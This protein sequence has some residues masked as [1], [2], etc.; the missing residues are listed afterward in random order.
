MKIGE[1]ANVTGASVRSI[2]YY[3][4]LGLVSALRTSGGQRAF[5]ALD[6]ERVR[7]IRQ[8]LAVGLG[9]KAI[10]D[11]LPCMTDP[12]SQTSSLTARLVQEL[13]RLRAEV[14]ERTAMIE[15]LSA[16]I[17]AAPPL[18]A[19]EQQAQ[20][21]QDSE[22]QADENWPSSTP[23]SIPAAP[24]RRLSRQLRGR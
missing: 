12:A 10:A 4:S 24:Q 1:L 2:R 5:C 19:D 21:R 11:V 15:A 23:M 7:V 20:A 9:T 8:L 6:I 22:H 18:S 17:Q 14:A 13:A 3:E 16:I